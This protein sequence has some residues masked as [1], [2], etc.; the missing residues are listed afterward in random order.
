[1]HISVLHAN[2]TSFPFFL[3][4]KTNAS[5]LKHLHLQ[6]CLVYNITNCDFILFKNLRS[7]TLGSTK[8]DELFITS[9]VSNLGLLDELHLIYCEFKS[10]MPKIVS[11]SLCY[12]EV[13]NCHVVSNNIKKGVN[14]CSLDCLKLT[15]L[16]YFGPGLETF[17]IN[18]PMLKRIHI[19]VIS[20]EYV[21]AFALLSTLTELDILQLD[22]YSMVKPLVKM[23]QPLRHLKQLNFII[24]WSHWDFLSEMEFDLLWI[25]NILQTFPQLQKLSIMLTYP[26]I[27][28]KQK[29]VKDV[30]ICSH[31]EIRVIELGG[32]VG[33]WYEIEFVMNALKYAQKHER[34][35]LSPYRRE[36]DSVDWKSDPPVWSQ[37]GCQR[38]RQKLQSEDVVGREKVVFV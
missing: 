34:I 35:V 9:L 36:H 24:Q 1:M 11:S 10:S 30:E 2:V 23:T 33:N 32:C 21:N 14:L 6:N 31:D 18:T 15:S 13:K 3:F 25:L 27:I 26:K 8:V 16:E 28:K 37:N 4:S 7:L 12:L 5:T 20:D 22:I 19:P 29:V 17:Y 38:I